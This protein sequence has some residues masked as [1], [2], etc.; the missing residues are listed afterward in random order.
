DA[1]GEQ[2]ESIDAAIDETDRL[3]ALVG[4][5]LQLARADEHPPP[6]PVDLG[7]LVS[8]RVDTWSAVADSVGVGIRAELP[9]GT[10]VVTAVPGAIE[11]ILDNLLD[12]ALKVAPPGSAVVVGVEAGTDRH[13]L[14]VADEGPGMTDQDK[15][16]AVTRFWRGSTTTQGSGL[17][18]AIVDALATASGGSLSLGDASGGGLEARVALPVATSRSV[19]ADR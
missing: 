15:A 7:L 8:E 3:T 13:V 2:V 6:V 5:L 4:D 12:N 1:T 11:Q 18:L 17:G 9:D 10:L 19:P 14:H 16:R